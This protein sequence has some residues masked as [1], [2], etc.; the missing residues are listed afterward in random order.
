MRGGAVVA[1]GPP[2]EVITAAQVRDI[3]GLDCV[4]IDDPVSR[5]PLVVPVGV[6]R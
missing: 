1:S 6:A 5:T 2:A 3:F 4:V